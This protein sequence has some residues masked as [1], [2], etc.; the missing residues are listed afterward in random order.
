MI[1]NDHARVSLVAFT[2]LSGQE[3]TTSLEE[4]RDAGTQTVPR[5]ALPSR[6]GSNVFIPLYSGDARK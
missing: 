3:W 2:N 6:D 4:V 1:V 5:T